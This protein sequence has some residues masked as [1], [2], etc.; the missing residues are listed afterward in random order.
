MTERPNDKAHRP[1]CGLVGFLDLSDAQTSDFH[2]TGGKVAP[3][4]TTSVYLSDPDGQT[5][6]AELTEGKVAP[7]QTRSIDLSGP[8]PPAEIINTSPSPTELQPKSF[9]TVYDPTSN[10]LYDGEKLT[11]MLTDY[12]HKKCGVKVIQAMRPDEGW[13]REAGQEIGRVFANATSHGTEKLKAVLVVLI[14][15]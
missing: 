2:L 8:V 5:S 4:Q 15:E 13:S 6:D 1:D 9:V 12:A 3:H 10:Q 11:T 7:H 14:E